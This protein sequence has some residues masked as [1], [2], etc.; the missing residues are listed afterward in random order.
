MDQ[1]EIS[2]LSPLVRGYKDTMQKCSRLWNLLPRYRKLDRKELART[3]SQRKVEASVPCPLWAAVGARTPMSV[4]ATL[5]GMPE[6]ALYSSKPGDS[7]PPPLIHPPGVGANSFCLMLPSGGKLQRMDRTRLPSAPLLCFVS[8]FSNVK[9]LRA[10]I[11][12]HLKT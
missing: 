1:V 5:L 6:T 2:K 10:A 11:R 12:H 4:R 3:L 9:R 7:L 8:L